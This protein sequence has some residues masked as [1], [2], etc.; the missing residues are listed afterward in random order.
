MRI[1][2]R[3]LCA[4]AT[5]VLLL[6]G[7]AAC[8]GTEG[9][10]SS[11]PTTASA[12]P[13][14]VLAA[15]TSE[16]EKGNFRFVATGNSMSSEGSVHA[17]SRSAQMKLQYS[18]EGDLGFSLALELIYIEPDSWVK[19]DL[20][21]LEGIPGLDNFKGGKYQHLDLSKIKDKTE[22]PLNVSEVD[23]FDSKLILQSI[24]DVQES[25]DGQYTGTLD[26]TKATDSGL[27]DDDVLKELGA[28]ANKLPFT[29][30]LNDQGQLTELT[31][32][33]PA[34]GETAAHE[35]KVTYEYGVA[36]P[37]QKPPAD[38]VVEATDETY[39][40]LQS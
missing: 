15:A 28:E 9:S 34:A 1:R 2:Q 11:A 17:E 10:P 6:P 39:K 27:V 14:Q 32:K 31:I 19:F 4:L 24:V 22:L 23:P 16:I 26:L 38:Q 8:G 13:K 18:E 33:I 37:A 7:L 35:L 5:A 20:S 30:K 21:G 25:G 29:A 40:M 12:D 36:T 3:G